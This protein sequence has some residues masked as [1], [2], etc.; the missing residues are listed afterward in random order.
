MTHE[1]YKHSS[2]E[3]KVLCVLFKILTLVFFFLTLA[4]FSLIIHILKILIK[5]VYKEMTRNVWNNSCY[6]AQCCQWN[7]IEQNFNRI[8]STQSTQCIHKWRPSIM[9]WFGMH[10]SEAW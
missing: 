10:Q 3:A 6:Y 8:Q 5:R 4:N 2:V 9:A 7:P 1:I